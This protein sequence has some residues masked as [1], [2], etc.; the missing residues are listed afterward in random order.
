MKDKMMLYGVTL[1]RRFNNKQKEIFLN[2]VITNCNKLNKKTSFMTLHNKVNHVCNLVINDLKSAKTIVCA[3]YD[4]ASKVILP[5]YK[6]YPFNPKLNVKQESYNL[7]LEVVISAL[8]LVLAYMI[9]IK[10][11][12]M[13]LWIKILGIV[14][15]VIIVLYCFFALFK[16]RANVFNFNRNSAAIA[17]IMHLVEHVDND[18]VA[19]VLLDKSCNSYEGL[20]LLKENVSDHQTIILLDCIADGEKTVVAHNNVDVSALLKEGYIDKK[21]DDTDNTLGYFNKCIMICKGSIAD[22]RFIVKNTRSKKDYR[23][24]V[25]ALNV[26]YEDLKAYLEA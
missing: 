19:Y 2:E 11:I 3:S 18:K 7:F 21:F 16:G 17:L 1:A 26:L 24:D 14:C 6:Y 23:V 13:T 9:V 5:N 8:L 12:N 25:D 22:H 15:C 10:T 20:K 4:T